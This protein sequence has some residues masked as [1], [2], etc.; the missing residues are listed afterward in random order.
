MFWTLTVGFHAYT[1]AGLIDQAGFGQ[2][3]LE[4]LVRD[5]LLAIVIY[6]N[7]LVIFRS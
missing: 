2:F 3:L 4:L 6:T 5:G 7:L 1:H